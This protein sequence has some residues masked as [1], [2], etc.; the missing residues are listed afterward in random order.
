[1]FEPISTNLDKSSP[2]FGKR[3]IIYIE[4]RKFIKKK[5]SGLTLKIDPY[6]VHIQIVCLDN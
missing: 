5:T 6:A 2:P 1:M 4:I 3:E